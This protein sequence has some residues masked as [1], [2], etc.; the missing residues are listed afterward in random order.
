MH[1]YCSHACVTVGKKREGEG[2]AH[3]KGPNPYVG[4]AA[5]IGVARATS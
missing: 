1:V 3:A 4:A 5:M 2:H